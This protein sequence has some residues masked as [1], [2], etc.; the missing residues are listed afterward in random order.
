MKV[1]IHTH[2]HTHTHI[3]THTH[4]GYHMV[5]AG[6]ATMSKMDKLTSW[7]QERQ[8]LSKQFNTYVF[9]DVRTETKV[10]RRASV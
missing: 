2:T 9:N 8:T 1:G 3:H 7:S 4:W 5:G 6:D 10:M